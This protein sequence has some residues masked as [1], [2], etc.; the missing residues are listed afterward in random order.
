MKRTIS[1][2]PAFIT[3]ILILNFALNNAEDSYANNAKEHTVKICFDICANWP[4]PDTKAYLYDSEG[5]FYGECELVNGECCKVYN[6]PDGKYYIKYTQ[7]G[8][9]FCNTPAFT[10]SGSD[11]TIYIEC[12]CP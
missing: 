2:V 6:V 3:A 5:N 9:T 7:D 10:I 8:S 12:T 1:A 4:P 11:V